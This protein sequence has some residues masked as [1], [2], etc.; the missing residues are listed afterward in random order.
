[1]SRKNFNID[2]IKSTG[3]LLVIGF[4]LQGLIMT[5]ENASPYCRADD[6]RFI[7]IY[8]RPYF[9]GTLQLQDLWSDPVHPLPL[10]AFM[11]VCSA[12]WSNLQIHHIGW[13]CIFFQFFYGLLIVLGF[14][15][16][17]EQTDRKNSLLLLSILGICTVIFSFVVNTAYTWPIM[18]SLYGGLFLLV[19]ISILANSYLN[20]AGKPSKLVFLA[21]VFIV[22][23]LLYSDWA[24]LLFLSF[25][26]AGGLLMIIEKQ[27]RKR[28]LLLFVVSIP[29]IFVGLGFLSLLTGESSRQYQS[30]INTL[31][32][33]FADNFMLTFKALATGLF[34]GFFNYTR[35]INDFS[36]GENLY[37]M[38]SVVFIFLYLGVLVLYFIKR[39][40]NISILPPLMMI[41][42]LLFLLS[43]LVFRY[44]PV[45]HGPLALVIGRYAI[46]YQV[47]IAGFFWAVYMFLIRGS[48]SGSKIRNAHKISLYTL[49]I[50]LFGIWIYHY[51]SEIKTAKYLNGKYPEISEQI[52]A[53]R[54]NPEIRIPWSNQPGRDISK[55][56]DFLHE[57]QLNVFAPNYPY[58]PEKEACSNNS[59]T[60]GN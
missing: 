7:E 58:P 54:I 24:I 46:Y 13:I 43:A 25:L 12:E 26:I 22:T 51:R 9:N 59:N 50:I 56:L 21:G 2:P 28:I 23:T 8:L 1:M 37:I 40:Y 16:S 38:A 42:S 39:L 57:H 20:R 15:Q 18:S 41:F 47:G 33:L 29:G 10:Y 48:L 32:L 5:I 6:W 30:A 3:V 35:F 36:L 19:A 27:N 49:T 52:R 53:K 34:S 31:F 4:F 60:G 44:N 14:L 11:F 17:T 55:Q 45:D